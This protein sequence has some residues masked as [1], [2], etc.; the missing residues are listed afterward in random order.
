MQAL[1]LGVLCEQELLQTADLYLQGGGGGGWGGTDEFWHK[2]QLAH[3]NF[4]SSRVFDRQNPA[5]HT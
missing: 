1:D 5:K 3:A 2:Q 4:V